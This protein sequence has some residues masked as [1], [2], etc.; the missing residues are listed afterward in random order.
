MHS[1]LSPADKVI[2]IAELR[3]HGLTNHAIAVRCRPSGPWQRLLRGVVL[4]ACGRPTR[5]QRL[6]A[7]IAY[8][9]PESVISGIDAMRA[10]GVDVPLPPDVLLLVP[11]RR[12]LASTSYLAVERTTRPPAPVVLADLPYAPLT[13]ATLDA[14]RRAADHEYQQALLTAAVGPCTVPS[15]RA[16]LD[17]GSQRGSAAVRALLTEDLANPDEVTPVTD[18]L[19]K[20][21]LRTTALPPPRWHVP[22]HDDTGMLLG[23]PDAWWPAVSLAWDVGP[24]AR[25]HDPRAWATAGVTLVR[26]DPERLYTNHSAVMD[27]LLAAY[28]KGAAGA[29]RRAS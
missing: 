19:A 14:A 22:V 1:N 28:A 15:L 27:E 6:R 9:G 18:A 8:A 3:A 4:M 10:H 26:T 11:A 16:E 12:R 20:R 25:H 5:R 2:T 24:Q 7:A 29:H 17:A 13:R 23:V 21:A